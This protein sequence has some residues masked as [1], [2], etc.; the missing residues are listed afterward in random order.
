MFCYF[1]SAGND[2]RVVTTA[3]DIAYPIYF[4][5]TKM[6][7]LVPAEPPYLRIQCVSLIFLSQPFLKSQSNTVARSSISAAAVSAHLPKINPSA[8]TSAPQAYV[9]TIPR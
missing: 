8:T 3:S 6:W 4:D 1:E 9:S 5:P 7:R 2:T